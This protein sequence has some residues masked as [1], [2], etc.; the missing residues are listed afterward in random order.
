MISGNLA[1][2]TKSTYQIHAGYPG[3]QHSEKATSLAPLFAAS[4]MRVQ[5]FLTE[6]LRSNQTG[7]ACVTATRMG[8]DMFEEEQYVEKKEEHDAINGWPCPTFICLP[9]QAS[10]PCQRSLLHLLVAG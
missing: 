1:C 9:D 10:F 6:E 2:E 5:A 4:A 3:I 8:M 7:S